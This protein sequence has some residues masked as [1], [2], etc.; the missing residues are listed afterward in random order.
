MTRLP[1]P[2]LLAAVAALA[3]LGACGPRIP[4]A[5]GPEPVVCRASDYEYLQGA[6]IDEVAALPTNLRVRVLAS[7]SFVPRD[8][9]PNRLTFTESPDG[10][11][12]RVFCG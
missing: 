9:D 10:T 12:S 5:S 11:V 7:D 8:F 6:Q 3:A 4:T 2:A 1:P